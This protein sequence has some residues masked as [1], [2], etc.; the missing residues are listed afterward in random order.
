MDLTPSTVAGGMTGPERARKDNVTGRCAYD[1]EA[2][3]PY[4]SSGQ[5]LLAMT[6]T[7]F[8]SCVS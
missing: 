3:E 6:A 8:G 5:P 4:V 7:P 2:A 1:Q